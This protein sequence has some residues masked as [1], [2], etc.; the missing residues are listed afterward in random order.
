MVQVKAQ[1]LLHVSPTHFTH[2]LT[3]PMPHPSSCIGVACSP[4]RPKAAS[5]VQGN[6]RKVPEQY[7]CGVRDV[8]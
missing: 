7:V 3:T 5:V 2:S 8:C 6:G 1:S 4:K